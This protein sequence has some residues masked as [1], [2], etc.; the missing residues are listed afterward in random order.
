MFCTYLE[1]QRRPH[2]FV[3]AAGTM[4]VERCIGSQQITRNNCLSCTRSN[5]LN[6]LVDATLAAVQAVIVRP[7]A[8]SAAN[9]HVRSTGCWVLVRTTWYKQGVRHGRRDEPSSAAFATLSLPPPRVF[10]WLHKS[11][12]L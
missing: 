9:D 8:C 7:C 10:R 2:I 6:S 4:L 5:S 11:A 3:E 1:L 12:A